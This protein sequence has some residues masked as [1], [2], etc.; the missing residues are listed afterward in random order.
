MNGHHFVI[1]APLN[2]AYYTLSTGEHKFTTK[3]TEA[4]LLTTSPTT[5]MSQI[6]SS[7]PRIRKTVQKLNSSQG[8]QLLLCHSALSSSEFFLI[9]FRETQNPKVHKTDAMVGPTGTD[10]LSHIDPWKSLIFL[11]PPS[12][13]FNAIHYSFWCFQ[14]VRTP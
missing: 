7:F 10:S 6:L 4:D 1:P 8:E 3:S 12:I 14:F 5:Y 2:Q 11:A 13:P 9:D